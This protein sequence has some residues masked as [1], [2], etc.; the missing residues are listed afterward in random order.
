MMHDVGLVHRDVKPSNLVF[1][2][3]SRKFRLIDFGACADLNNGTNYVPHES[4]IDPAYC[5]PEK[6]RARRGCGGDKARLEGLGFRMFGFLGC[7]LP[8]PERDALG[9]PRLANPAW[10][11]LWA[12][13]ALQS[14]K[15]S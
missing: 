11:G 14:V 6:V 5:A 10:Y 4:F 7:L 8:K 12:A 2:E 15:P 1:C 3:E 9:P 13:L